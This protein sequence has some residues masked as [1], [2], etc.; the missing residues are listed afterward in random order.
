MKL[1][2]EHIIFKVLV[3][4]LI[5]SL[6]TPYCVKF[7]HVFTHHTHEVCLGEKNTHLHKLDL[8]CEFYKFKL[9]KNFTCDLFNI[10][11][12]LENKESHQIVSHYH[13]LSKY[14]SLHFSLRGP[15][16]LV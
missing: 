4:V 10:E 2:R 11:L 8:D 1:L 6:I 5:A 15:P 3:I 16:S 14:Q 7:A 13:F 9:A 12:L